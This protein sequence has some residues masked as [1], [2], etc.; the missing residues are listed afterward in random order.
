MAGSLGQVRPDGARVDEAM[1]SYVDRGL[2]TR[3]PLGRYL[4]DAI[5][6][7]PDRPAVVTRQGTHARTTLTYR[8]LGERVDRVRGG[9]AELGV[10]RGDVVS[11][12]LPNVTEFAELIWAIA[13]LGAVYSGVPTSYGRRETAFML[14]RTRAKV[15]VVPETFR[16]RDYVGFARELR[17]EAEHLRTVVVL[18]DSPAEPGW[19]S[20]GELAG[21]ASS[22]PPAADDEVAADSLVHLGFTSGT[23]GEPKAVMNTHQTLEAVLAGWVEHVGRP[24]LGDTPVNL[25]CSPIG[26]H[27]GFLWGVLLSAYVRGTAVCLDRWDPDVAVTVIRDEGVTTMVAAPTF[28]QDLVRVPGADAEGLPSLRLIAIPGAP[29]PRALV[30]AARAQLGCFICSA[31]GMTEYGIGISAA[32]GMDPGRVDATDG[33]AAT[34]CLVRVVDPVTREGMP[35]GEVGALEIS[36]PGLFLGYLDRP[37]FTAEA[38]VDGWFRTGDLATQYDDGC[39]ELQGRTKDIIIRGGEN[40]PVIDVENLLYRHPDVLDAALVGMPDERLGER[41]CAVL[42]VREG[43]TLALDDLTTFLLAEGLSKH[44]LPE[45]LEL[46]DALPKTMSGKIRKVELREWLAGRRKLEASA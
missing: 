3:R 1:R 41:A 26:H 17:E 5:A 43:A 4:R 7:V 23:T 11:V 42:A 27:T 13:E 46:V 15:L 8:E 40:I 28:L 16:G 20:F 18:G 36:G 2:W 29:I 32:P 19:T 24:S 38:I 44:F 35:A 21:V 39:V 14:R 30:P 22:V 10:G 6:D 25:V 33:V 34:N 31:W 37:D 9:L 12:M 45:R